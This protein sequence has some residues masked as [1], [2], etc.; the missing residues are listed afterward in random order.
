MFVFY[1]K[2]WKIRTISEGLYPRSIKWFPTWRQG[3]SL[4][5]LNTLDSGRLLRCQI[6]QCSS[7]MF[8]V[9]LHF[10]LSAPSFPTHVFHTHDDQGVSAFH[11]FNQTSWTGFPFLPH[12][13]LPSPRL[14]RNGRP[15]KPQRIW[16][17]LSTYTFWGLHICLLGIVYLPPATP[18]DCSP[19][20]SHQSSHLFGCRL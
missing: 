10:P 13:F 5:Q 11:F 16:H 7:A 20:F 2:M 17:R 6:K 3:V 18:R 8:C 1:M 12:V 15:T 9:D 19:I 14:P 4:F